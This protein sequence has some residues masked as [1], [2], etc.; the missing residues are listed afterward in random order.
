MYTGQ[1]QQETDTSQMVQ[2][3]NVQ[4]NQQTGML[5]LNTFQQLKKFNCYNPYAKY[6]L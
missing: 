1:S 4:A 5:A 6:I 2:Q 3:D